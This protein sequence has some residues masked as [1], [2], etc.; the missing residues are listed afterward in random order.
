MPLYGKLV[1][2]AIFITI[3][4]M[5]YMLWSFIRIFEQM[6]NIWPHVVGNVLYIMHVIMNFC[7][8]AI[9]AEMTN[10]QMVH[11]KRML[12]EIRISE[13]NRD[14]QSEILYLLRYMDARPLHYKLCYVI[15]LDLRLITSLFSICVTYLIL[16]IQLT[17]LV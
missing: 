12:H 5:L 16:I 15:P 8:P 2:V 11:I 13:K 9:V 17:H 7:C 4:R 14:K 6:E 3:P 1:L 10:C